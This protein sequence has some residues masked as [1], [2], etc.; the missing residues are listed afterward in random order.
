MEETPEAVAVAAID[1][2]FAR[3][4]HDAAETENVP[5]DRAN[6]FYDRIRSTI[7][8]YIDGKGKVLGKT[9][10]FLLLVPDVFILLWRLTT[11]ARVNGKD[12]VLLG[13]A[14]AYY[15]MPFDLIPEAIVGPVGYLDDLVFGVYV[16]NKV[17]GSVDESIV[18]EHWSGSEDVLES[19]QK[20]L[21]AAD[22]LIGKDLVGKIK[23]MMGK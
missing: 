12:K 22:S 7:Q 3:E 10:E 21:N 17:L 13:S 18:R 20:V 15:V 23:K 2:D 16:L 5:R 6:R 19:I 11:D 14:V 9:T 8:R 4:I 1:D